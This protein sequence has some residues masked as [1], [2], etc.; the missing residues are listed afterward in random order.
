MKSRC[1]LGFVNFKKFDERYESFFLLTWAWKWLERAMLI[2]LCPSSVSQFV[3]NCLQTSLKLLSQIKC[4]F[5]LYL[6]VLVP[7]WNKQFF[8]YVKQTQIRSWN[9]PVLSNESKVSCSRK[10]RGLL[11]GLELTTNRYPLITSQT[12]YPMRHAVS[13]ETLWQSFLGWLSTKI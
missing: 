5:S 9:Q 12:C 4:N 6:F 13:Y 3:N 1:L 2:C 11:M 8:A 10:Q 7:L